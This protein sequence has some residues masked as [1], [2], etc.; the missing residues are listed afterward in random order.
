MCRHEHDEHGS[1]EHGREQHGREEHGRGHHRG[2]RGFGRR[3][4]PSREEWL[5]R[6]RAHEQRLQADLKNVQELI[7]S[8]AA[9]SA[10]ASE[11]E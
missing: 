3:G 7:G 10:P 1:R 4:F 8:L 6:L 2:Y 5:E 11:G 9:P